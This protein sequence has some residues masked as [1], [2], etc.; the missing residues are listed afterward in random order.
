MAIFAFA[1]DR[2]IGVDIE[3][4]SDN[5]EF[6]GIAE[7]NFSSSEFSA[8]LNISDSMRKEAFFH[9]WTCKEAYIKAIG[10]GLSCPMEK[11]E[12]SPFLDDPVTL[13]ESD[14]G[15]ENH[16]RWQLKTINCDPEYA[17]AVV[18]EGKDWEMKLYCW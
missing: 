15:N 10:L 9:Y 12:I 6:M 18:V 5:L 3:Y 13:L 7:S 8:L 14:P 4:I 2:D 1:Y 11:I 17:A 16:G